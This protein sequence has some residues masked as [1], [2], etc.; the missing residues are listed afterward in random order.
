M[1][2]QIGQFPPYTGTEP[3]IC[4]AFSPK[5][6]AKVKKTLRLLHERGCR[7]W[8]SCRKADGAADLLIRQKRMLDASLTI[9]YLS[10]AACLDVETKSNLLV[11]QNKGKPILCLSPDGKDRKLSMGLLESVPLVRLDQ[12]KDE[13]ELQSA[14]LHAEGFSQDL[15]GEAAPVQ[16]KEW[17]KVLPLGL[18]IL[19]LLLFGVFLY[20]FMAVP[21]AAEEE[22]AIGEVVFSDPLIREAVKQALGKDE[23]IEDLTVLPLEGIPDSWEDLERLPSLQIIEIPQSA[24]REDTVLPDPAYTVRLKGGSR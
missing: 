6:S 3:Y 11:Y 8:Y 7:V 23:S 1:K 13:K 16:R 2:D 22:Q 12:C 19:S 10:D 5:D 4:L 15:L 21:A 9:L 14:V 24:I 18:L 17:L 20:R